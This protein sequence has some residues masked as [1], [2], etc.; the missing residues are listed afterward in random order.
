LCGVDDDGADVVGM[1]LEGRDFL[2]GV[3]VVYPDLAERSMSARCFPSQFQDSGPGNSQVIG[4]AHNPVLPRNE[5]A[6][7]DGHVRELK[8]LDDLLGL[9]GPDVNGAA[10]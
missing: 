8:R 10:V 6:S 2:A 1:G 5:P 7:A 9:V 3:V 4:S